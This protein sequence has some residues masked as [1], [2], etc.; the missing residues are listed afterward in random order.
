MGVDDLK[1]VAGAHAATFVTSGMRVGLGTGST[2]RYTIE[3]L[4]ASGLALE[5]TA[6]SI[7]THDLATGLGL[8]VVA[9]DVIGTIDI[10][11]DGADEVDPRLNLT[12]GGGGALTREK[13]VAQMAERFVVVADESKLVGILGGFGTPLEVLDFAPG[14]VIARVRALGARS[15]S[16]RDRRSDNANLL[17][18]AD[19]GPTISDPVDLGA[20]LSAIAGL[21]E[22]GLF[23]GDMVERVVVA[24]G[25]GVHELTK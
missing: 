4:A 24:D 5:C 16:I 9:P 19:F 12:K 15:V 20:R 6:T 17:V 25:D 11:I 18:D 21:V 22:H 14:T 2:V 23:Y 3:A 8:R 1:R 13:V 7:E 10:A